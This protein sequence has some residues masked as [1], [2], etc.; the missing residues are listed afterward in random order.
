MDN[1]QVRNIADSIKRVIDGLGPNS[2]IL[3]VH[4]HWEEVVGKTI[5]EHC[6]PK[7]LEQNVLLVEVDHPGW[8]TEI[9]Y[10]ESDL[11]ERLNKKIPKLDVSEIK[12]RVRSK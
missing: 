8:S 7:K 6:A 4:S 9:R 2:E 5:A 12:V 11:L 10:L 3:E 1:Q